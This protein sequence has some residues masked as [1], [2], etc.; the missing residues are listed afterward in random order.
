MHIYFV[1]IGGAGVGP[2]ALIA[3]QAGYEVSGSDAKDSAYVKYLKEKDINI[4]LDQTGESID[5]THTSRPI[6]W[7][8]G[9]SSIV[10]DNPN[11]A[12]L[13]FARENNIEIHERDALLN[14]IIID[15]GLKLI[16]IAGTH[17]KTTTTAMVIWLMRELGIEISYSV[18]AKLSFADMSSYSKDSEYFIYECDEFH[19][20]FLHFS[21]FLSAITGIAWDHHEVFKTE[22]EY[23][24][25]FK[26]FLTQSKKVVIYKDDA[27]KIKWSS[28]PST[29]YLEKNDELNNLITLPGKPFKEDAW[30]AVNSVS[31]LTG[32]EQEILL[33]II[34]RYPGASRRMERLA[35]NFYTDYAHTP[36]K[37]TG[38]IST[39]RE[40]LNKGQKL[41]AVYEPLTNRRQHY[42]K[43]TYKNLFLDADYIYWVPSYLA[44]E[45]A[46]QRII[47]PSEF[48]NSLINKDSA[49]ASSLDDELWSN[50][51]GHLDKGDMVVLIS[52]GGGGSLDEW[53]RKKL[54]S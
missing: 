15:N 9:V 5:R 31:L 22:N 4:S 52:G 25:S 34:N 29:T 33:E 8:V 36:E 24:E 19:K 26:Q 12:E 44:R 28:K 38:C 16:A 45:D 10:R 53:A 17:G 47:E 30:L 54:N 37:I 40:M 51:N 3:K 49:E 13:I 7:I 2:L 39:A 20:N 35:H 27:N 6:D 32:V 18:G 42:I 23:T 48:V 21:P 46:N 50:I 41:V 11:H 1:G 43:D 14:K